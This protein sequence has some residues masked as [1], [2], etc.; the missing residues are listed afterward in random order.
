MAADPPHRR[1]DRHQH[2]HVG[3]AEQRAGGLGAN[4]R[5]PEIRSRAHAGARTAWQEDRTAIRQH[6]ARIAPRV[7]GIHSKAGDWVVAR[8]HGRRRP[9]HPIGKFGHSG[10]GDDHCAGVA[11]ALDQRRF[12]GRHVSFERERPAG[13]RHVGGMDVVLQGDRNA[14]QG[15]AQLALRALAVALL[16]LAQNV[17]IHR[18]HGIEFLV[19]ERNP[20]QV[21]LDQLARTQPPLRHRLLHVGNAGFDDVEFAARRGTGQHKEESGKQSLHGSPRFISSIGKFTGPERC[22]VGIWATVYVTWKLKS[23]PLIR[24]GRAT[25]RGV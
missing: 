5:R 19:V 8:R 7:I 15:P 13:G 2:V 20:H 24:A 3:G 23:D 16:G 6:V 21:L 11:Q 14:V 9:R 10:L 22:T 12:I 1:L 18:D 4:V 25:L 17:R